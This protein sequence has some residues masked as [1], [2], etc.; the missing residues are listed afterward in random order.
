M[1]ACWVP[2]ATHF[3]PIKYTGAHQ[4]VRRVVLWQQEQAHYGV[5]LYPEVLRLRLP[6]MHVSAHKDQE[7]GIA[8]LLSRQTS[9]WACEFACDSV[10]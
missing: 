7:V 3:L 4:R 2:V 9:D 10:V 5:V 6:H 8:Y 1:H